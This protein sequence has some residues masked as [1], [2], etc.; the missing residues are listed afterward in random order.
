[1]IVVTD[2][3][4]CSSADTS[5]FTPA[6]YLDPS[7]PRAMQDLNLRCFYNKQNLYP[8]ERYINGLQ[9]AAAGQRDSSCCSARSS[10]CRRTWSSPQATRAVDWQ[11]DA[12]RDAFYAGILDDSAHAGGVDPMRTPEQG[13]NLTPVVQRAAS[14]VAYPPRRIVEVARGFGENGVV[15]SICQEDF[16]PAI[17][18]IIE[19]IGDRLRDPC[20]RSPP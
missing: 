16:G 8:L 5:H 18:A 12:A 6:Q 10:A 19:R 17:D 20:V 7:D 15:Q 3:E 9:G 2:E 13:G 14:G 4:D 1:M 11:D